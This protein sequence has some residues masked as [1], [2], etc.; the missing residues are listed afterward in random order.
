MYANLKARL[1]AEQRC[2]SF[3]AFNS[4]IVRGRGVMNWC[5]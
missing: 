4:F 2:I 3:Y 5:D 1:S